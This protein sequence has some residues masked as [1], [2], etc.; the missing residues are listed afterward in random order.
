MDSYIPDS[1]HIHAWRVSIDVLRIRKSILRVWWSL[2]FFSRIYDNI[3][4]TIRL[5]HDWNHIQFHFCNTKQMS[6][7]QHICQDGDSNSADF[8]F[9]FD[10]SI[11]TPKP[12]S[13]LGS[14]RVSNAWNGQLIFKRL[15]VLEGD[16][17]ILIIWGHLTLSIISM[18]DYL[19]R[20]QRP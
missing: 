9:S 14:L 15:F 8:L 11:A 19:T 17:P 4:R 20:T 2:L 18:Q 3:N 16:N 1:Y 10:A 13:M 5:Q 12:Q 6:W 7:M